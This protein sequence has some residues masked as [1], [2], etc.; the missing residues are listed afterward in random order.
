MIT[1]WNRVTIIGC[2]LIGASFALGLLAR[3]R[4]LKLQAGT[5]LHLNLMKL[6]EPE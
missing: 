6:F 1:P 2:G 5:L 3:T 4:A